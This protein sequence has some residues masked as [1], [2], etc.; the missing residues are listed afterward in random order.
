MSGV[1]LIIMLSAIFV[2]VAIIIDKKQKKPKRIMQEGKLLKSEI[3]C[4]D[5]EKFYVEKVAFKDWHVSIHSYYLISDR[6]TE[7]HTI[8]EQRWSY[9]DFCN[10]TIRLDDCT[11]A[12]IRQ[13]EVVALV[14]SFRP[15]PIDE[16][17][18]IARPLIIS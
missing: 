16:F 18:R 10:I 1:L 13:V 3:I 11:Y 7:G 9:E 17:D 15:I 14:R 2:V 8:V 12:L 5:G 6:L 4:K